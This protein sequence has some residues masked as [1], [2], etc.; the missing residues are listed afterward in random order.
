VKKYSVL[1]KAVVNVRV[2]HIEATSQVEAIKKA[3][4]AVDL[5]DLFRNYTPS[6]LV[7]YTEY[8]DENAGYLVDEEGDP[9]F[10]NS[11][12]YKPDGVTV[13]SDDRHPQPLERGCAW[14]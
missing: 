4:E 14:A 12:W 11:L 3:E 9:E 5:N 2:N 1:I 7:Q 13:W 10:M 8:G 6:G